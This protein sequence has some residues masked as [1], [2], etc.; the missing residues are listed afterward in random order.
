M[1]IILLKDHQKLGKKF[2]TKEVKIGYA[3]NFLIPNKIAIPVNQ[4]SLKH[5]K[6]LKETETE[7][8][9]I[10]AK[11]F[12]QLSLKLKSL[13]IEIIKKTNPEGKLFAAV[14]D[15]DIKKA[16]KEI[17][18]DINSKTKI[19]FQDPIKTVGDHEISLLFGNKKIP[20]RINVKAQEEDKKRKN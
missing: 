19:I 4:N 8:G 17:N 16:I 20:L 2:D 7:N 9:R 14:N 5:I 6:L 1:K 10:Q 3:R 15:V 12:D 13:K 18:I 11:D